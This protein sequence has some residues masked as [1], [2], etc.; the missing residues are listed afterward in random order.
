MPDAHWRRRCRRCG[1]SKPIRRPRS[2]RASPGAAPAVRAGKELPLAPGPLFADRLLS[3]D[4]S[5]RHRHLFLPQSSSASRL[6]AGAAG[7]LTLTQC[8][9]RPET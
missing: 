2:S 4:T 9:V 7:F 5:C 3:F 8:E 1:G 6:T